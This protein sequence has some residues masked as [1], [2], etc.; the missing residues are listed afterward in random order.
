MSRDSSKLEGSQCIKNLK[1]TS[2]SLIMRGHFVALEELRTQ[3]ED[4]AINPVALPPSPA[5]GSPL[6]VPF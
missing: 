1:D 2:K 4:Q 6:Y 3:A 5:R